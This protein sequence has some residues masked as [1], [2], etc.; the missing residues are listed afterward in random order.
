MHRLLLLP[1]KCLA[2]NSPA[3]CPFLNGQVVTVTTVGFGD[4]APE[5]A[6]AKVFSLFYVPIG[7][8]MFASAI[9]TVSFIPLQY[10]KIKLER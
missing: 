2:A 8:V 5:S 6:S 7:V 3:V 1:R 4:F 10:R 9:N